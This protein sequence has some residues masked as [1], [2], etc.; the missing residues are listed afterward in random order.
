[1]PID[2]PVPRRRP[3]PRLPA[4]AV[5]AA[6]LLT[7]C[8]AG[9]DASGGARGDGAAAAVTRAGLSRSLPDDPARMVLPTTGAETRWTQGLDV[10]VWQVARATAATCA[11][12]RGAVLPEAA[13]PAFIRFSELPDL[14]FIALHGTSASAPVPA[15]ATSPTAT[16]PAGPAVQRR[17]AAEGE[18]AADALRDLYGPLQQKWFG[19]LVSLRRDPDTVRALRALPDCLAERGIEVPD[20][21]GFFA[22]ADIRMQ[23]TDP[24]DLPREQRALGQA[25]AGCMRPVEAIREPA[26]K[27]LLNRFRTTHAEE[28]DT[29]RRTLLPAL[30]K[31]AADHDLTLVFPA[32]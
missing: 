1:M 16:R 7:A 24:A 29:L 17:C 10:F 6:A 21:N 28:L 19:E 27:H 32:P 18:A 3:S 14:D 9:S 13:P 2:R 4:L 25:Y 12:E 8:S 30:R 31:A 22:L 11:N 5:I 20:E 15:P 26:R 23:T